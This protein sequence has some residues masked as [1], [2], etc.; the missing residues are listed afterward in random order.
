[1]L[2]GIMKPMHRILFFCAL[3]CLLTAD[4]HWVKFTAGPYEVLSDAGARP[5][6]ETLVHFEEFRHALGQMVG[7]NDLQTPMPVRIF[8]FKNARGW[9]AP[10]PITEG[11]DRYAIVLT[12][13]GTVTPAIHTE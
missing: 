7:E 2:R 3:P 1:R 12:E 5:G 6:R 13:K 10:A 11:R 4:D 9:T 8:V